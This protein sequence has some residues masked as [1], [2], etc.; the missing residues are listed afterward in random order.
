MNGVVCNEIVVRIG[1][2]EFDFVI[3]YLGDSKEDVDSR[4]DAME[5]VQFNKADA[6]HESETVEIFVL[7]HYHRFDDETHNECNCRQY[8]NDHK[9]Y[10]SN[11]E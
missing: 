5:F 11:K 8:D 10:W 4:A 2:V 6:K 1:G 3:E 9:P 7:P